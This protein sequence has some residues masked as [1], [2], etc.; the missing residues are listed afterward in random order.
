MDTK[1]KAALSSIRI[2]GE[3]C[4]VNYGP[5][6]GTVR[7]ELL[8]LAAEG[9]TYISD[10]LRVLDARGGADRSEREIEVAFWRGYRA[11]SA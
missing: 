2:A 9:Y 3:I 1:I 8:A 5:P 7:A 4:A 6:E 10:A 11:A